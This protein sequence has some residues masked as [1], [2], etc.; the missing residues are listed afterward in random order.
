MSA[1]TTVL[2]RIA[3]VAGAAALLA[4]LVLNSRPD[5]RVEGPDRL[6]TTDAG[7][8]DISASN[9]PS[10][11]RNPRDPRQLAVANRIDSPDYGCALRVSSDA[12][13]TWRRT[14]VP[15]PRGEGG[16]C[17]TPDVAF[18]ADGTLH[19]LYV[20]L[21]GVAN[22]PQALWLASSR[23]G[24][25]TLS[26]PTKV[27]GPLA[28][29]ARLAVDASNPRRLFATW[30]QVRDV[31][32]LRFPVPGNPI[33]TSRSDDGGRTWTRPVTTSDPR[34][35]RVLAPAPAVGPGGVLY[36]LYLDVG[37]DRL[38]YEGGHHALGGPAYPGRFTL[39]LARSRD[40]GAHWQDSVVD[41]RLG[42]IGRFVAFLPPSPSLA[43]DRAT[44]RLYAAFHDARAGDPD[45]WVWT[46]APGSGRWSGARVNARPAG[47]RT[48]Q[49]LPRIAVAPDGRL[50]VLYYDRNEDP[51]DRLEEVSLQSSLDQG[52]TFT[53]RVRVSSRAFDSRVGARSERGLPDPGSRL[54]LVSDDAGATA[55]WTDTRRGTEASNKQDLASVTVRRA[56][57]AASGGVRV[58]LLASGAAL[59]LIGLAGMAASARAF[60][61]GRRVR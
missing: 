15:I 37:Q 5:V 48:T 9:S 1:R 41:D 6:V 23:D 16:K 51:G 10:L 13:A 46:L 39:V 14:P 24:G 2:T 4:A 59:L 56:G 29:Q 33:V 36:V 38:D 20:T 35:S 49:E 47:D 44:G 8:G 58:A 61:A 57:G 32:F 34:R 60:L 11:A 7:P 28:F 54:G 55:V 26:E 18:A 43:V 25:R 30:L 50:D 45:V 17:F 42:A 27:A 21:R 19:L 22:T 52:R 40:G 31:G 53:T 12:G 3:F